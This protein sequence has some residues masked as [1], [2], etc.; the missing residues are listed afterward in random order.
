MVHSRPCRD[1]AAGHDDL[2]KGGSNLRL[3]GCRLQNYK[4][5]RNRGWLSWHELTVFAGKNVSGKSAV[6]RGLSKVDPSDGEKY[7][8]LKEPPEADQGKENERISICASSFHADTWKRRKITS[9]PPGRRAGIG[10]GERSRRNPISARF[11]T[12]PSPARPT[13]GMANK[14][15][16][17]WGRARIS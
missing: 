17:Q 3:L 9:D 11:R 16:T 2:L 8:G 13:G 4:K 7:D 14:R 12:R 15:G 5:V 6:F 1:A 10:F